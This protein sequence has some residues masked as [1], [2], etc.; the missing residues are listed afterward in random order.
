M[1]VSTVTLS[2]GRNG[3]FELLLIALGLIRV[4]PKNLKDGLRV[5]GI[6]LFGDSR[7]CQQFGPRLG[8]S[9]FRSNAIDIF[10]VSEA[11][12]NTDSIASKETR[13]GKRRWRREN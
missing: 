8:Q 13:Q 6:V 12:M 3:S 5:V 4:E 11:A 2:I 7:S 10:F 9:L 1:E